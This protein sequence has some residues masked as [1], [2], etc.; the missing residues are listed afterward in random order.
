MV[1]KPLEMRVKMTPESR[2]WRA[3]KNEKGAPRRSSFQF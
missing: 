2:M 3:G 1:R